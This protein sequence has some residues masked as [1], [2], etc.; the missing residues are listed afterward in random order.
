MGDA[1]AWPKM[2]ISVRTFEQM[3]KAHDASA[4]EELYRRFFSVA[5]DAALKI[6]HDRIL[7][8]DVAQEVLW[9][10]WREAD[11]YDSTRGSLQAWISIIAHNM[12]IDYL[13][14]PLI[15]AE[16]I[17]ATQVASPSL[18]VEEM[19]AVVLA[20]DRLH[21]IEREVLTLMF[22]EGLSHA[23]IARRLNRPLGTIKTWAR[24]ALLH[25]R[26]QFLPASGEV[27]SR[28]LVAFPARIGRVNRK[29][30]ETL[31]K[32]A[33]E[34][35]RYAI[36]LSDINGAFLL[37]N[38]AADRLLGIARAEPA[39]PQDCTTRYGLYRAD[40]HTPYPV[41]ELPLWRAINGEHIFRRLVFVRNASSAAGFLVSTSAKPRVDTDGHIVGGILRCTRVRVADESLTRKSD[42]H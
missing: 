15:R 31:L 14:S 28:S 29:R 38:S 13:R 27:R 3:L 8:E 11:T 25:I 19:T 2:S 18:T 21:P 37:H 4:A 9:R 41:D 34:Q 32:H 6:L 36:A 5:R 12:A 17:D 39:L 1:F 22:Y 35:E 7:A 24:T 42:R 20:L 16:S 30:S 33:I 23:E 40:G 26:E 10:V